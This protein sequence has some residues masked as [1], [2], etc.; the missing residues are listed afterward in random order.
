MSTSGN[1]AI[2]HIPVDEAE[3]IEDGATPTPEPDFV[4]MTPADE[5]IIK[6][7]A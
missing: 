2:D 3:F 6:G 5:A 1:E 7:A 4:E